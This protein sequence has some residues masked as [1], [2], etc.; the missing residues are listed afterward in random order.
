MKKKYLL[1]F[2]FI[3]AMLKVNAQW[4]N[5]DFSS[6]LSICN[7]IY[8]TDANNGFIAGYYDDAT[9]NYV[10]IYRTT[11]GGSSWMKAFETIGPSIQTYPLYSH[12]LHSIFFTSPT[13]GF[14]VGSTNGLSPFICKTTNGGVSWDTT[15]L[16]QSVFNPNNIYFSSSNVGYICGDDVYASVGLLKTT[17]GGSTWTDISAQA[18][19]VMISRPILDI[20]FLNDNTGYACTGASSTRQAGIFK[21]T[22]GGASWTILDS[23]GNSESLK[24]IEFINN[25]LGFVAATSGH[26]YKTTDGGATW[27]DISITSIQYDIYDVHFISPSVGYAASVK[28]MMGAGIY[29]TTNGGTSWTL[30]ND[31]YLVV[32]NYYSMAFAGG[33]A[34]ACGTSG[35]SKNN[36]VQN[37]ND[38]NRRDLIINCYPNP[39]DDEINI[40]SKEKIIQIEILDIEGKLVEVTVLNKYNA[41]IDISDLPKGMYFLKVKNDRG[42][43]IKKFIKE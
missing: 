33:K 16:T 5:Y 15:C 4:T 23:I 41:T 22:D 21:T 25:S 26:L 12:S 17:D 10:R 32:L 30:D 42:I 9:Y 40:Y 11:N 1:L 3:A 18:A 19:A 31:G 35:Y 36:S 13:K 24:K 20:Y 39:V 14:C 8:F 37:I 38:Y 7:E 43:S 6:Y 2:V 27:S 34:F 29:K 28:D